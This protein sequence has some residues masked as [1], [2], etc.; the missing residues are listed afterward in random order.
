MIRCNVGGKNYLLEEVV[1]Y[2]R[3]SKLTMRI[4]ETNLPVKTANNRFLIEAAGD[5]TRVTVSP[6][7]QL[8]F[9]PLGQFLDLVMVRAVYRKGMRDLFRGLKEDIEGDPLS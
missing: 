9:G 7:Y 6:T 5:E 1:D 4:T 3:P 2:E 8:K